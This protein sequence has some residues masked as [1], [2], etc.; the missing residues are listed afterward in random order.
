[1]SAVSAPACPSLAPA[2][3]T[4]ESVSPA[5]PATVCRLRA[6][7][8][9]APDRL[10]AWTA[11]LALFVLVA[12]A[13]NLTLSSDGLAALAPAAPPPEPAAGVVTEVTLDAAPEADPAP[14]EPAAAD[15]SETPPETAETP[16]EPVP[17][18][19]EVFEVPEPPPVTEAMEFVEPRPDPKPRPQPRA[20]TPAP[21]RT[22]PAAAPTARS[23]GA[24][25]GQ[26]GGV[27]GGMAGGTGTKPAASG[28]P[29]G[30][31]RMP[32]PPY[33]SFARSRGLQGTVV[34]SISAAADGSV[35]GVSVAR[36]SGHADLD[37]YACSWIRSR[38]RLPGGSTSATQTIN[39]RLR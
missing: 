2:A 10:M 5:R 18:E 34:L 21:T 23:G 24:P 25:G 16:P 26:P 14:P 31:G 39:F 15:A 33:P 11:G 1:M 38:W 6:K 22:R 29:G 37:R 35:T 32:Q 30:K 28:V 20:T 4:R 12:G 9:D 3:A 27:R 17:V 36:S 19:T 7:D 13:L 8:T